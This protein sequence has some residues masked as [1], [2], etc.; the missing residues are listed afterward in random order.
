[1]C[2]KELEIEEE[3]AQK[4]KRVMYCPK[5]GGYMKPEKIRMGITHVVVIDRCII[6]KGIFME[7]KKAREFDIALV[8]KSFCDAIGKTDT[9]QAISFW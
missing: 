4:R 6:C 1:M 8:E 7:D 2:K 9:Q 5:C 3:I